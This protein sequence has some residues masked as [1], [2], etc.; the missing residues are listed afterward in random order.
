M[1]KRAKP[2]RSSKSSIS[3]PKRKTTSA[4]SRKRRMAARQRAK[5][6]I[7][8]Q[9]GK[10]FVVEGVKCLRGMEY[11]KVGDG[12]TTAYAPY[13]EFG[14]SCGQA[15]QTLSEAGLIIV[16]R[17]VW[18]RIR[19]A[20]SGFSPSG[21][22]PRP[23]IDRPGWTK[24]HFALADGDVFSPVGKKKAETLFCP[25]R[26]LC[27]K[28]GSGLAWKRGVAGRLVGQHLASFILMTAFAA[29]LLGLARKVGNFGFEIIGAPGKGKS[30][31]QQILAST[32][33]YPFADGNGH[34]G[35]SLNA[36]ANGLEA[37]M[38]KYADMVMPL[39]ESTLF[40]AGGSAG[41]RSSSFAGLMFRMA[42]G[43]TKSR[44][45]GANS[46][47]QVIVRFIAVMSG[48]DA[49]ADVQAR[50]GRKVS[51]AD[52]DRMITLRLADDCPYGTFEFLPNGF[53][54]SGALAD[55]IK[56]A[57][58]KNYGLAIRR[59][60]RCLVNECAANEAKLKRSIR[61]WMAKFRARVGV[62]SNDGSAK[63]L[64]SAFGLVYA[65]GLLAKRYG[66]LPDRFECFAAA[67]HCFRLH[68]GSARILPPF[69]E[70]LLKSIEQH[71]VIDLDEVALTKMTGEELVAVPVFLKTNKSGDREAIFT[72]KALLRAFP[73][74]L[75]IED[76]VEVGE[77]HSHDKKR[78]TRKRRVR[79]NSKFEWAYCFTLPDGDE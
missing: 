46:S 41:M 69:R 1:T 8:A 71:G 35:M 66:I 59:F 57:I 15:A 22:K 62:D 60:L 72:R 3:S 53:A 39:E 28:A 77:V 27:R 31:L 49:S 70:R 26:R 9:N 7:R 4:D 79:L 38:I 65:A 29:P 11:I 24:G 32:A 47:R 42:D 75:Q 33:G 18:A 67:R 16:D 78:H 48:N 5:A 6:V 68:F 34:Y 52:T 20:I 25:E 45:L 2:L 13:A 43:S 51:T 37:E 40:A 14:I 76:T 21:F 54:S 50:G 58:S 19:Y 56:S 55:A 12:E 23:L 63:R 44:G 61:R 30:T 10:T 36:T 17:A 74:W 64:V 73:D